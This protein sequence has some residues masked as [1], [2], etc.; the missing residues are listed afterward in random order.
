MIRYII[1]RILLM[2]PVLIGVTLLIFLLQSV[3]PGDPAELVLG[4]D[5]TPQERYDWKE[6]YNLN[7]P[8]IVQYGKYL[9]DLVRG[10][11]GVSYR[12]GKSITLSIVER[13][14][15]TILLALLS[16]SVSVILGM[17]LGIVAA[18]H[19]DSWID[20]VARFIG[21]LGISM[22]NFWFALL[23]IMLFALKLKWLPVSG[24]YGPKYWIL[25]AMTLGILGSASILRIT[26]SSVLDNIYADFVRTARSKGQKESKV[27]S[28]HILRNAM[29]PITTNIG[30]LVAAALGGTIILE[31][32]FAIAGLGKLMVD[33]INQRDY[34]LLRGC[35]IM[36]AATASV[37][38]L[39]VD[40]VYAAIDPRVKAAFANS[41]KPIKLFA[42]LK[43]T[44]E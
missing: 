7:D 42:K 34:P 12:T 26:R 23:L 28:H 8:L 15:T 30:G 14:P 36:I 6:R 27:V 9:L 22:P 33:A 25:P 1:R 35:V 32:I 41:V 29:I 38:N 21:I 10:D 24:F 43:K 39:I 44:A 4:Q 20:S 3:T 2:I 40:I 16:V 17:A 13:W 31:Q 37:I 5:S 11:F 18:L 19:R